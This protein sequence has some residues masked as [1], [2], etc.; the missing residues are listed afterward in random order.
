MPLEAPLGGGLRGLRGLAFTTAVLFLQARDAAH[1]ERQT[2]AP[3]AFPSNSPA[4]GHTESVL[5]SLPAAEVLEKQEP[6]APA[7]LGAL[8]PPVWNRPDF[9]SGM[10]T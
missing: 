1:P 3:K 5:S 2:A 6:P 8:P 9:S 7:V 4:P 10:G